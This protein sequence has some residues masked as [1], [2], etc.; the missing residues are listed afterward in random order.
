MENTKTKGSEELIDL[1][2]LTFEEQAYCDEF[3]AVYRRYADKIP[4]DE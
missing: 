4:D 2:K 3:S 1:A